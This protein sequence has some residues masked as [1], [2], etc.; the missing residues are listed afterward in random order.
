MTAIARRTRSP[1]LFA[2][3]LLVGSAAEAGPLISM[4]WSQSLQGISIEITGTDTDTAGPTDFGSGSCTDVDPDHVQTQITCPTGLVGASGTSL[5]PA[6]YNVSLTMPLF[7]LNTFTTGGAINLNTMATFGG[8]ASIAGNAS[9]AVAIQGIDGMVTIRVAAHLAKGVNASM[10]G[11]AMTTLVKLP[12]DIGAAGAQTGYFTVSGQAHLITVDFY[13]WT[14]HTQV[15]TG[16]TSKYAAAP[17][18]TV[19]A[20]GSIVSHSAAHV[21]IVTLVAPSRIRIDGP[22]AQRRAASFTTLRMTYLP[23]PSALL[24]LGAGAVG[25]ALLGGRRRAAGRG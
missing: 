24:L 11:T 6:L 2:A 16:L 5:G 17:T 21:R 18:P 1:A 10:L 7:Q 22:L 8:S 15:F 25:L 19:V 13:G 23:E 4:T 9:S 14:P 20:M 3:A 12:L